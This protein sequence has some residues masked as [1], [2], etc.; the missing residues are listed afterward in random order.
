[1]SEQYCLFDSTEVSPYRPAATSPSGGSKDERAAG[2]CPYGVAFRRPARGTRFFKVGMEDG[3]TYIIETVLR[4]VELANELRGKQRVALTM[5][6]GQRI[7]VKSLDV[8]Y[9]ENE[10]RV[11]A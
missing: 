2:S 11:Q 5:A 7:E 3:K 4:M 8:R 6:S 1:M 9:L 10:Y